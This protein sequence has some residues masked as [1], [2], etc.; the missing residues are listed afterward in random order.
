[1]RDENAKSLTE[2]GEWA[3]DDVTMDRVGKSVLLYSFI[4]DGTNRGERVDDK[5][6]HVEAGRTFR[7]VLNHFM[8]EDKKS[9]GGARKSAGAETNRNVFPSDMDE[10]PPFTVVEIAV[11]PA[12]TGGFDSGW[13]VLHLVQAIGGMIR[14]TL[15][16]A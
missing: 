14:G 1:M 8:Y 10:I 7:I 6:S 5:I 2:F 15:A 11:S 13:G 3:R 4:K 9:S 12:N 16:E